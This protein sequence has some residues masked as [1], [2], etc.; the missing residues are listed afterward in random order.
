MPRCSSA[1]AEASCLLW[2]GEATNPTTHRGG[3]AMGSGWAGVY[4]RKGLYPPSSSVAVVAPRVSS[5]WAP[6]G[7]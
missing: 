3:V 4:A 6:A 1:L 2:Q 5:G 7:R